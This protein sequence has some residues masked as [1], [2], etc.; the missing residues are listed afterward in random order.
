MRKTPA[1]SPRKLQEM[2]RKDDLSKRFMAYN[3]ETETHRAV[4]KME[5][6]NM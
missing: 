6:W 1:Q 4:E 3:L 5:S 2:K